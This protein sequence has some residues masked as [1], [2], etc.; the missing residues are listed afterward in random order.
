MGLP[1]VFVIPP[2]AIVLAPVVMG[3]AVDTVTV[4]ACCVGERPG[5]KRFFRFLLF[6][7][8]LS[9]VGSLLNDCIIQC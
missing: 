9:G 3:D 1:W 4:D 2:T 6:S 5:P 8:F 7:I